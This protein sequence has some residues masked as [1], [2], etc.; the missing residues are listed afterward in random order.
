MRFF[1]INM[2]ISSW[3]LVFIKFLRS[4]DDVINIGSTLRR[5][6]CLTSFFPLYVAFK[7]TLS[8]LLVTCRGPPGCWRTLAGRSC[9]A[10]AVSGWTMTSLD[11]RWACGIG[12]KG[13][14]LTAASGRRR[15]LVTN[16]LPP[17]TRPTFEVVE[18]LFIVTNTLHPLDSGLWLLSMPIRPRHR[19]RDTWFLNQPANLCIFE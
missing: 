16:Y 14:L 9:C 13:D 7:K 3:K 19:M 11:G 18:P 2:V 5:V 15:V 1:R 4:L 17:P 6:N 10:V 12:L 8:S